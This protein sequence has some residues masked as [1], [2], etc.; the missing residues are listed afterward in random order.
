MDLHSHPS[1]AEADHR[2]ADAYGVAY[3]EAAYPGAAYF[4]VA[5][6]VDGNLVLVDVLDNQ[7]LEVD[8]PVQGHEE[9]IGQDH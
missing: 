8:N 1:E 2:T 4:E 9:G 5:C 7:A 3:S 6:F